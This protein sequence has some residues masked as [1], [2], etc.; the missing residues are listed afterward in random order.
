MIRTI[1]G[2]KIEW[3]DNCKTVRPFE[4]ET[5][6]KP[7]NTQQGGYATCY[8]RTIEERAAKIEELTRHGATLLK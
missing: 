6:Y 7:G 5:D 2:L 1:Y 8:Y 4:I 3:F